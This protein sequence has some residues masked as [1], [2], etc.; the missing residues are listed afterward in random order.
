MFKEISNCVFQSD[1]GYTVDKRGHFEVKYLENDR[2]ATIIC[3]PDTP[4]YRYYLSHPIKW[5]PPH[6]KEEISMEKQ[7]IIRK[8]IIAV[9]VYRGFGYQLG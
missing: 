9:L 4:G 2:V 8:R 3:Q 6:D 1:E 5:N 7:D